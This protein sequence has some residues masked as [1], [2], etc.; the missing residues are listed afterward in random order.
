MKTLRL[1]P[2]TLAIGAALALPAQAQSLL[3]LYQSAKAFDA[4]YQSAKS[5]YEAN[6]AKGE[7][8]KAGLLPTIGLGLGANRSD[9]T[10]DLATFERN[11]GNQSATLSASQ[12]L[13]RPANVATAEQ[14]KKQAELA[15]VQLL[16]ADQDLIVRVSQAYFDVLA[17]QDNLDF[18]KAQKTAVSEQLASAKRNFEVGTATITDTREAQARSDLVLAQEIASENDLR[19]KKLALDQLTGRVAAPKPLLVPVVLPA[20]VPEEVAP[21]VAQSEELSPA[22]QQAK[23]ALEVAQLETQKAQAG[24]KPTLDLTG[25]Y[26]VNKTNG[27]INSSQEYRTNV[28]TVGLAFN[29]PLFAGF[30][31]Q[32]RVKETVALE[33]KS[34]SDLDAATRGVAQGTRSAFFGVQSGLGQ[35]KA[36]EAAEAS[37][38]SALD[39]TKLG[40][41]VGVRINI[42]VLNAQT[43]LFDTKAKLAKARYDVLVGSLK[44]RQANGSLKEED[45]NAINALLAQ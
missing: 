6:L 14:G 9:S 26:N 18:V 44:L 32:N 25:S 10:S 29:L 42:D 20:I 7:Q 22:V 35:V 30:A 23:L 39:A 38:Q 40:Y 28:A 1:L 12:P 36:L 33:E 15:R 3:D 16:A 34:R 2:L 21:W 4:N 13:Y 27:T 37:S 24:H 45:I 8:A 19:I 41:Q 11:F 17:A 43:T 31:V 5:L